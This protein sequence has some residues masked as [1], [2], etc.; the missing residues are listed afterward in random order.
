MYLSSFKHNSKI[1]WKE[2]K[3]LAGKK[4]SSMIKEIPDSQWF[5]HF[6]CLF[7]NENYL[8]STEIKYFDIQD[9]EGGS[10]SSLNCQIS[11]TEVWEAIR[12]L[13]NGKSCGTD[14]VF[15]EMLKATSS[16]AVPFL[17][18]LFNSLFENSTFPKEWAK[19]IIV[20]IFKKGDPKSTCNYR[21]VSLLSI[22]SKCYTSVLNKRLVKWADSQN[23]IV[24]SQAGFRRGYSTA[25]HIFTLNAAVEKCFAKKGS[26]L[27]VCFVD[28]KQ[29]FDSVQRESLFQ[30]LLRIGVNDKFL[31][32]V[33][34]MY[35]MVLSCVRIEDRLTDYFECPLGLRQGCILSPILFSIFINEIALAIQTDG[36]HGVQFLPGL[37]ELFILLFA[38][39]ITL[40]SDSVIG[41]Q[42]QIDILNNMCHKL[43]LSINI[44]KTK[45]M[46]FRKGGFL[47]KHEKWYLGEA[48]LEVVN[49]YNYLGFMFTTKMSFNKGVGHLAVKGKRACIDCLKYLGMLNDF[50]KSCFCKIFDAQVQPVL[51]YGSEIWG[52]H[53]L[54]NIEKVH[55]FALKRFLNV[56]AK[57]PNKFI[58]GEMGRFPLFNFSAIRCIKYWLRLLTLDISRLPKQAY[59]MLL[60]LDEK[61]KVCWATKVKNTLF[62]MGLGHA[63]VHHSVGSEKAFVSLFKQRLK[64]V[65]IQEW[66]S[67]L[68]SKDIYQNYRLF[69]DYFGSEKYFDYIDKKCFRDFIVKLRLGVLPIYDSHFSRTFNTGQKNTLCNY[70]NVPENEDHFIFHCSLYKKYRGRYVNAK[71]NSHVT[72][73]RYGS[74]SDICKLSI[75]L[76]YATRSRQQFLD[77]FE[78]SCI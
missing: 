70:C 11:E 68:S 8:P 61:G 30:V 54:D 9:R 67:S 60:N 25:D 15:A 44:D 69:K 73:L 38:D 62:Y 2:L 16:T 58:Y 41:L 75:F 21:G 56:H 77:T 42:N 17:A 47:G 5:E 46:V 36:M 24:E 45:I 59:L 35:E 29:A 48:L 3:L 19:A 7:N 64:D 71:Y 37:I 13:K 28:L 32:A 40:L 76:F 78:F 53:R 63:W 23:V 10:D 55:T 31:K 27:Y 57:L 66:D 74:E 1:F 39:D 20:P 22:V 14:Q 50:T 12:E 33:I 6:R 51:L 43:H 18:K 4:K 49:E 72:L 26:K 34:A 65:F 52:L